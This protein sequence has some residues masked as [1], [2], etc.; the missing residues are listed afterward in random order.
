MNSNLS[1]Q[2]KNALGKKQDGDW[3]LK[4]EKHAKDLSEE[5]GPLKRILESE[6]IRLIMQDYIKADAD[7]GRYQKIY[8]RWGQAGIRFPLYATIVGVIFLLPMPWQETSGFIKWLAVLV[9]FFFLF[10]IF[11]ISAWLSWRKPFEK[12]MLYRG[13]AEIA[14]INLFDSVMA[15][16]ETRKPGELPL[17]PLKLEYF[18]RYQL[19]VQRDYYKDRGLEHEAASGQTKFWKWMKRIFIVIWGFIALFAFTFFLSGIFGADQTPAFLKYFDLSGLPA[20]F[21]SWVLAFGIIISALYSQR[22]ARS[23]MNMDV[24]NAARYKVVSANLEELTLKDLENARQAALQDDT[25]TVAHFVEKIHN[26]ISS[27]H[28]EWIILRPHITP[29]H[30]KERYPILQENIE[31]LFGG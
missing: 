12:W 18:I 4:P 27:E 1:D 13:E 31:D 10:L 23:L 21:E 19:D 22:A 30:L 3:E 6:T 15:A 25:I 29:E 20:K 2:V 24:R 17:L 16:D 26:Q 9:Q 5:A 7:A 14:R 28:K 11:W 8:K